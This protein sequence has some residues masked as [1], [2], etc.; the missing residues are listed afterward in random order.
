MQIVR[1]VDF[2][3]RVPNP[4]MYQ[5]STKSILEVLLFKDKHSN[6]DKYI[7]QVKQMHFAIWTNTF[8]NISKYTLQG[9]CNSLESRQRLGGAPIPSQV[10]L[11]LPIMSYGCR[12][13]VTI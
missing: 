9:G 11:Q 10:Q 6:Y 3:Q 12:K 4:S 1:T 7:L 13:K 5:V 8:Y 2:E